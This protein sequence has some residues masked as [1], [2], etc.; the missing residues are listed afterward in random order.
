MFTKPETN[1]GVSLRWNTLSKQ[2]EIF[3]HLFFSCLWMKSLILLVF[4]LASLAT[5][6]LC[7]EELEKSRDSKLLPLF[8]VV[9][10]PVRIVKPWDSRVVVCCLF[11]IYLSK[12]HPASV[13]YCRQKMELNFYRSGWNIQNWKAFVSWFQNG[14]YY[15]NQNCHKA[16]DFSP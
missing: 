5:L 6:A 14:A 15:W 4:S 10:F 12:I 3:L 1:H 16:A 8:Q 13:T 2:L 7:E 11:C 9:R